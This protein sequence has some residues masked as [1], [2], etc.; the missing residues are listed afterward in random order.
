MRL[1]N[2]IA[3]VTGASGGLGAS[4]CIEFAS[5]GA[6]CIVVYHNDKKQAEKTA[7]EV[8]KK[9]CQAEIMGVDISNEE[10]IKS[11]YERVK[12][13]FGQID[14]V[15]AN[16]GLGGASK[17]ILDTSLTEFKRVIDTNLI[18]TYLTIREGGKLMAPQNS[19]KIV[20]MSSVHGLG[21]TH[22]C[23]LYEATKAGIINLTKGAAFDLS[24]YNIQINCI[25]PGAVP[26]PKDPPPDPNS[27]LYKA[28]MQYT[29]LG[30][31]GT[32]HDVARTAVFLASTDTDWITGQVISV[33]GGMTAGHL[34]P[35]FIHYGPK[36]KMD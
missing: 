31:F 34:I 18:G 32:P 30:R 8:R 3:L 6:D 22:L 25:A 20:T 23:S 1:K 2:K 16:A 11:M 12:K 28:W 19:G 14:I 24:R 15:V 35:S 33:D 17:S 4:I 7:E 29:P 21:G 5:E 10:Q 9:G 27:S 26:V 13:I 36:P